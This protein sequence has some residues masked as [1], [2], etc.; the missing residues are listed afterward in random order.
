MKSDEDGGSTKPTP[1]LKTITWNVSAVLFS[2]G[3]KPLLQCIAGFLAPR[4]LAI[5]DMVCAVFRRC[6][7]IETTARSAVAAMGC[8][9][10]E[11]VPVGGHQAPAVQRLVQWAGLHRQSGCSPAESL[12]LLRWWYGQTGAQ[13]PRSNGQLGPHELQRILSFTHSWETAWTFDDMNLKDNLLRGVYGHGFESPRLPQKRSIPP[14]LGGKHTITVWPGEGR[15]TTFAIATLQKID[16]ENPGCQALVLAA[17][18]DQARMFHKTI[19]ALGAYLKVTS[20]ACV[21]GTESL[22]ILGE[23]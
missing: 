7:I 23:G 4:E 18:C 19:A 10:A 13:E 22:S 5:L 16:P 2:A 21:S 6:G 17:S 3:C 8:D 12:Y 15:T 1:Q 14:I 11:W 20:H 9:P